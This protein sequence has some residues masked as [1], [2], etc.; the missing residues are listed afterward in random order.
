MDIESG[1]EL[2]TG[3]DSG[4]HLERLDN[5]RGTE[6][7]KTG[8][9]GP[10]VNAFETCLGGVPLRIKQGGDYRTA[11]GVV[12]FFD[13]DGVVLWLS[14]L[15]GLGEDYVFLHYLV[16]DVGAFEEGFEAELERCPIGVGGDGTM[17]AADN[18][19]NRPAGVWDVEIN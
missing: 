15:V 6:Q 1:K 8:I 10:A 4:H 5:I 2:G 7:R 12:L 11:Q 13:E 9:D 3:R 18:I 17:L 14:S 16:L 19:G